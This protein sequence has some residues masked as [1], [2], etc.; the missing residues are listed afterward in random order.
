MADADAIDRYHRYL[1]AVDQRISH[2]AN[3]EKDDQQG[4]I[5]GDERDGVL[6]GKIQG[7][8]KRPTDSH[9]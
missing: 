9:A 4:E 6:M 7:R 3:D 2:H 8:P 1:D 5:I